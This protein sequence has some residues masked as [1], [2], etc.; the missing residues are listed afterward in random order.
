M[1]NPV[2]QRGFDRAYK[3]LDATQQ[4]SVIADI[5]RKLLPWSGRNNDGLVD[6]KSGG[7]WQ[8]DILSRDYR[9]LVCVH[10][11]DVWLLDIISKQ[12]E[13]RQYALIQQYTREHRRNH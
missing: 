5:N 11:N 2:R 1:L 4:I 9:L 10:G 6:P 13:R 12:N 7:I 8:L 3:R